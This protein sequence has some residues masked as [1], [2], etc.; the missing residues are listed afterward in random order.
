M[1]Y[2]RVRSPQPV[3]QARQYKQAT[4][5]A[6]FWAL[7]IDYT[8]ILGVLNLPAAAIL[9]VPRVWAVTIVIFCAVMVPVYWISLHTVWSRS[10]GKLIMGLKVIGPGGQAISE[11]QAVLR[12]LVDA[13][14][15][16]FTAVA[17]VAFI[18]SFSDSEF[19]RLDWRNWTQGLGQHWPVG[20]YGP[21]FIWAWFLLNSLPALFGASGRGLRDYLA[22]TQ[23]VALDYRT[24]GISGA[25]LIFILVLGLLGAAT[26]MLGRMFQVDGVL[27]CGLGIYVV[28][29]MVI[30]SQAADVWVDLK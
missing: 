7:L 21:L 5:S 17:P 20:A 23:V 3:Q 24:I 15:S 19:T 4:L 1:Q 18:L 27:L 22:G 10:I 8:C 2:S 11:R 6:R 29:L 28:L 16:L 30:A 13:V 12:Y 26:V 14:L 9:F 25:M